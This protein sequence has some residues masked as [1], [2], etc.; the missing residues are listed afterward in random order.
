MGTAFVQPLLKANQQLEQQCINLLR[1]LSIDMVQKAD[2]GHPGLPLDAAPM[3]YVLWR[4]FLHFNPKNPSW[5]NRDRFVLSAGHGSALLY[6]LLYATGFNV[7][8]EDLQRFRQL[9]SITPGHPERGHTPGV[10]VTTGP[11][12]QGFG[13]GI[14]LSMAEAHLASKFNRDKH[15]IVDHY[16][17]G[18]VSD[19]DLMEGV[20][21]ESASLAGHLKLGKLIYLYDCNHVTL[22]AAADIT[23]TEDVGKRFEAYHW[24]VLN[25]ADGNDTAALY[26]ALSEAREETE[27]PSL[28]IVQTHIGYGSPKQ[29]SFLAHG[30]PLG[31]EAVRQTKQNL[32][33][34]EEPAFYVPEEA[35]SEFRKAIETGHQHETDWNDRFENYR[36]AYPELAHQFEASLRGELETGWQES[37]PHFEPS[38][39][40]ISTRAASGK[41]LNAIAPILSALMGGSGDLNPSTYTE[42]KGMGDFES[43]LAQVPNHEG[44]CGGVWNYAGRNI[45]FGI[46]EHAMGAIMSGLAAHGGT[47]PFG[48]TFLTFSDYMRPSI[49]LAALMGLHVVYVFTHDSI[50]LGEDGPTHQ[51]IEQV[52]SLR[53][54]PQMTVIRP[55]DGNET[56]VAWQVA[57]EN[58]HPVSLILTRQNLPVLDRQRFAA[59]EGLRRGAYILEDVSQPDI[60]LIATGSEVSLI[61]EAADQLKAEGMRA[62]VVS[63]PSWELFEQ[64][65]VQYKQSIFPPS[66]KVRLAVEAG[67]PQGWEKYVGDQG[68]ILGIDCFGASGSGSEVMKKFG[69]TASNVTKLAKSLLSQQREC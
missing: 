14:G 15:Q 67:V 32:G 69:F 65:D 10:E 58:N 35:L 13:N 29:D 2:S 5:F 60:I 9:D 19:G 68:A 41:V 54:I 45:A 31:A 64:Q 34:P 30:S 4:Q 44:I 25:V 21:A 3:A 57:L 42:L 52:A 43:P 28:I 36:Q 12:G 20:A 1:F 26:Q 22:S 11:L 18:I 66:L 23:F 48:G 50:A 47:I 27:R 40:G 38:E 56:V 8:L 7:S 53:A 39:K 17:Y 37:L 6:S 59:A 49:R 61:V 24:Q 62:R 16:T 63:M 55:A 46:R 51:P 33:W